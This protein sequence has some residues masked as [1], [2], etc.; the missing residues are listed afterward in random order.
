M[1]KCCCAAEHYCELMQEL[2]ATPQSL[3]SY[4]L[5]MESNDGKV[6][7]LPHQRGLEA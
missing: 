1:G 7:C 6:E 3:T 2:Y 5:H 4:N